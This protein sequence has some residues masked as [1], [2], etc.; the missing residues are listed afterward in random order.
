MVDHTSKVGSSCYNSFKCC[1]ELETSQPWLPEVH[2]GVIRKSE[3]LFLKWSEEKIQEELE[4]STRNK[5]IYAKIAA[6]M[7][8]QGYIRDWKHCRDK[9]K[10]LKTQYKKT[11][12][13]SKK[14]GTGRVVCKFYKEL[15]EV[16]G[17]HPTSQ[18]PN[19]Y[20]SSATAVTPENPHSS[21]D[22]MY[23]SDGKLL[24]FCLKAMTL[25]SNCCLT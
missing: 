7:K 14:T 20:E 25:P 6:G 9:I 15:D 12:D 16:L 13:C 19:L 4:G 21:E 1:N 10:N 22:E 8:K 3:P 11:K 24:F 17:P 2:H 5:Q 23:T 18:P